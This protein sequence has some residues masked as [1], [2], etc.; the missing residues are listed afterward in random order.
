MSLDSTDIFILTGSVDSGVYGGGTFDG[1]FVDDI[2]GQSNATTADIVIPDEVNTDVVPDEALP[3][4]GFSVTAQY[5][6]VSNNSPPAGRGP[7]TAYPPTGQACSSA[8]IPC[9]VPCAPMA[10]RR[11]RWP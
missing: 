4:S 3:G 1:T 5:D 11:R 2:F 10:G 6:L 7:P 8:L 9:S